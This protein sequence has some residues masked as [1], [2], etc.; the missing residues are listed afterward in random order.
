MY[1]AVSGGQCV[2]CFE[3]TPIIAAEIKD[4]TYALKI[5]EGTENEGA[6][7][8][9]VVFNESNQELVDAFNQ[10]LANIKANG[11]YDEILAKYLG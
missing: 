9:F 4:G 5:V 1:Q 3:D 7:Y 8:G 11:T 10:G 6:G 2:A